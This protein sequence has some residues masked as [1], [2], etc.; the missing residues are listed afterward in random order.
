M[1]PRFRTVF[2]KFNEVGLVRSFSVNKNT[3]QSVF[4]DSLLATS[5]Y[6]LV[7]IMKHIFRLVSD[8][9]NTNFVVAMFVMTKFKS[10]IVHQGGKIGLSLFISHLKGH[11]FTK[12]QEKLEIYSYYSCASHTQL[13]G[14]KT[15]ICP[16]RAYATNT[17]THTHGHAHTQAH[18]QNKTN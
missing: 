12:G 15:E 18:I 6:R 2:F 7:L 1:S 13:I 14:L 10:V 4:K 3:S 11:L 17:H 16:H 9:T 5:R 8:E